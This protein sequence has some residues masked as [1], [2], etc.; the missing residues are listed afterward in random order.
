MTTETA[1]PQSP[2]R[3]GARAETLKKIEFVPVVWYR[4][5]NF[6]KVSRRFSLA[7]SSS[8][9]EVA[10]KKHNNKLKSIEGILHSIAVLLK[11]GDTNFP[12]SWG[13]LLVKIVTAENI[14]AD[15]TRFST[16]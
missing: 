8:V 6:R 7:P 9:S 4:R 16:S 12:S 2:Q 13:K 1:L 10:A 11:Y 15:A 14:T 3:S 5:S